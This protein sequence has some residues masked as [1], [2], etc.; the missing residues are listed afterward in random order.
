M[1][2]ARRSKHP[3]ERMRSAL[4]GAILVVLGAANFAQAAVNIS[5]KPTKN[6][7]CSAGVC[8]PT[9]KKA[10]LNVG[11]L[12]NLLQAT[13]VKVTTGKHAIA[14]E[15]SSALS[16]ASA[17]R[18]TLDANCNVTVKAPVTV[19][20]PGALTIVTNDGGSGCTRSEER[21]VGKECRS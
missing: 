5:D 7:S 18:L 2:S 1:S 8:S 13:D 11:D 4:P 14:I 3:S 15:I 10:V 6:M 20:G 12:A 16:W 17:N 19:A 21:R 9:A